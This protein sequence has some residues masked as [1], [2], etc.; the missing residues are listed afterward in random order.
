[1]KAP[2]ILKI[3]FLFMSKN[4]LKLTSKQKK[5]KQNWATI[6]NDANYWGWAEFKCQITSKE[7]MKGRHPPQY[8][9]ASHVQRVFLN[10]LSELYQ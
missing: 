2:C 6:I 10:E 8:S 9:I 3:Y 1:M 4:T 7:E 5:S